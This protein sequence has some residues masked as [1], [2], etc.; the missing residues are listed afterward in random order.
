M[1]KKTTAIPAE[2]NR[3]L[4]AASGENQNDLASYLE[5]GAK[6]VDSTAFAALRDMLGEVREKA[7]TIKDSDRL[8]RRID[9]LVQFFEETL[10]DAS[11]SLEA[12]QSVAF[13]LLYFLKGFDR[14]P[15]SIPEIGLMDDALVIGAVLE[16]HA[17]ALRAHWN[18][19]KRF[20]PETL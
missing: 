13:G 14:I 16:R 12:R 20:W 11:V 17:S 10:G 1:K 18:R 8:R 19:K 2:L 9:V 4:L 3:Y 15:D 7:A 5:G 6:H